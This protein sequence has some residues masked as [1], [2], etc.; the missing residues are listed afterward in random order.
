MSAFLATVDW[1]MVAAVLGGLTIVL[2]VIIYVVGRQRK[3]LSYYVLS[4][5][6][7]AGVKQNAPGNIQVL[8]GA[9]DLSQTSIWSAQDSGTPEISRLR[10]ATMSSPSGSRSAATRVSWR[11]A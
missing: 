5:S 8:C 1:Q 9:A 7:L 4:E 11:L 2:M 6:P 10:H 3:R